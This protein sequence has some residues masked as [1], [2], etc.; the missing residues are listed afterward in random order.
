M[1]YFPTDNLE[2]L[3]ESQIAGKKL[4]LVQGDKPQLMNWEEYGLRISVPEDSLS[5][6]ETV[7]VSVLA[8][9]GGHF[10]YIPYSGKFWRPINFGD[11][12]NF[13]KTPK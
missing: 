11:L 4:F 8:L 10:K 2:G 12:A 6:S 7:E 9:V 13:R 1:L 5:A 3:S